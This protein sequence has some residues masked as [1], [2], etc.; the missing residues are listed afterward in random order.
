MEKVEK[1]SVAFTTEHL[2][3]HLGKGVVPYY[4]GLP[5]ALD[6]LTALLEAY[7]VGRHDRHA[8]VIC[9]Q[10]FFSTS[11]IMQGL[12]PERWNVH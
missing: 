7:G 5:D 11:A 8:L 6:A 3:E 2:C 4:V 12:S 1:M 10:A 9:A